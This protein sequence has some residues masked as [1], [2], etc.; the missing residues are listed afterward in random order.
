MEEVE[1]RE[2]CSVTGDYDER[3]IGLRPRFC[4]CEDPRVAVGFQFYPAMCIT[5]LL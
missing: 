2:V 1:G 5:A 3:D 4:R